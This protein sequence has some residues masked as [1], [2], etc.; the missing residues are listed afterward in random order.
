M[1]QKKQK[2]FD[3]EKHLKN[4]CS[5]AC[6]CFLI[7][8]SKQLAYF[9]RY[10]DKNFCAN[11][12]IPQVCRKSPISSNFDYV[13]HSHFY[14][15]LNF[16]TLCLSWLPTCHLGCDSADQTE[17]ICVQVAT[18]ALIKCIYKEKKTIL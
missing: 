3:C 10:E 13:L 8:L 5:R 17:E 4:Q 15:I 2:T 16:F 7:L 12:Y 6:F 9:M 14:V 11:S 18:Y 1:P